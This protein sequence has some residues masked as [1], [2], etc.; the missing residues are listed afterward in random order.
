MIARKLIALLLLLAF[1]ALAAPLPA[2]GDSIKLP[3]GFPAQKDDLDAK[4]PFKVVPTNP[5]L[6]NG[7]NYQPIGLNLAPESLSPALLANAESFGFGSYRL[8]IHQEDFSDP[9][10]PNLIVLGDVLGKLRAQGAQVMMT[11]ESGMPS[12]DSY[13]EF[14]KLVDN[15]V[16]SQ[17]DYYQLLDNLNYH[18]GVSA[19][20]YSGLLKAVRDYRDNNKRTFSIVCGGIQGVD[21]KF[22]AELQHAYIFGRVDVI[23]FDLYPDPAHMEFATQYQEPSPPSVYETVQM[24]ASLRRYNK[25]FFITS[26]GVST[27]YAPL[28]VSQ[29][30]QVSMLCRSVFYLLNGGASRIFLAS[31][32]DTD[33]NNLFPQNCMGLYDYDGN[34]KP[35]AAAAHRLTPLLKG[36]YFFEPYYLF[37]MHNNFPAA[38]DPIFVHH[39]YNPVSRATYYIY[40]TSSMNMYDR[41]TNLV[42]YRP[43]LDPV[44]VMNLL[45]GEVTKPAFNRGGNL[46]IFAGLPLSHI[47]FVIQMAGEKPNG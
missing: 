2:A 5:D 26:L 33:V 3:P 4:A 13:M 9:N 47:P 43:G 22:I 27:A 19:E 23:A 38:G 21:Y 1:G 29:L 12:Q 24:M 35:A 39:L 37:Q 44:A 15:E 25:P 28:G 34:E 11:M 32:A 6:L 41:T 45:T 17:V 7:P 31:L 40:W 46:L 30:D 8:T 14:F 10:S 20:S 36:S 42:I 18:L 16:G